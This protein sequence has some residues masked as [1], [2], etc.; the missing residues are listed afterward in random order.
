VSTSEKTTFSASTTT[1]AG[2][3][4]AGRIIGGGPWR[5]TRKTSAQNIVLGDL[6]HH[7][8]DGGVR[9]YP[10]PLLANAYG[11]GSERSRAK[12]RPSTI[13]PARKPRPRCG[14]ALFQVPEISLLDRAKAHVLV[15]IY[16]LGRAVV[17]HVGHHARPGPAA[18]LS[19]H[20]CV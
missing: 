9:P 15:P 7:R 12:L 1:T 19:D 6:L 11:C 13:R 5:Q 20:Y 2:W 4:D 8:S 16:P 17:S 14:R 10:R 3:A 18:G